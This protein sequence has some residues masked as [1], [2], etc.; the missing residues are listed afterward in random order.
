MS[1]TIAFIGAGNMASALINGLLSDGYAA[2]NIIASDQLEEKRQTLAASGVL[3][4]DSNLDAVEKADVVVLAVKPQVL[5]QVC[6]EIRP[7]VEQCQ[8]LVVSIAAG[9]R[10][11]SLQQWLGEQTAI[12]R[13]MPNTP[14]MIQAGA[15][16]LHAN[17]QASDE[18]K[19][20]AESI[21]R[22][23]GVTRWLDSEALI[24]TATAVSGSGPAYFFLIMEAM[25]SAA[26]ELGLPQETAHLLTLQTALGAARMAMESDDD[27]AELRR[28]VTS[29][30]GTTEAA[31]NHM[32]DQDLP[33]LFAQAINK[34]KQRSEELSQML[35]Q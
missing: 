6:E 15:T 10:E 8:P 4:T 27:A 17:P 19:D 7:A 30:G 14:A 25:E 12:V 16:V 34:A 23:V 35:A 3:T 9:I 5:Q 1:S 26:I 29:P 22:A 13:C 11:A 32:L 21:L 33:G 18:Q 2:D 28:K 31:I 20:Q 24:D